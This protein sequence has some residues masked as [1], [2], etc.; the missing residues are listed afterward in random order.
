MTSSS[1]KMK[2]KMRTLI[3]TQTEVSGVFHIATSTTPIWNNV[4]EEIIKRT[5]TRI[6]W[7]AIE[8]KPH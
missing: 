1:D 8:N 3:A 2:P 6:D 5:L 7:Q 4:N